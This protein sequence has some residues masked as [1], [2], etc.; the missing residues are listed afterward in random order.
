MTG[1]CARRYF[2]VSMTNFYPQGL[3]VVVSQT[4]LLT[5]ANWKAKKLWD[6]KQADD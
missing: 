5:L 6:S 2:F 3:L 4:G 1:S